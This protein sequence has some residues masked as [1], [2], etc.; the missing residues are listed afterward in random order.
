MNKQIHIWK[1]YENNIFFIGWVAYWIVCIF[2][3]Q[4]RGVRRGTELF[5]YFFCFLA[6]PTNCFGWNAD[7]T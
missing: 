6:F 1:M 3:A 4:I 7:G 5:E 2:S